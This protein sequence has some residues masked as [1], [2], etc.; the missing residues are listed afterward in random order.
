MGQQLHVHLHE[1]QR[2]GTNLESNTTRRF[3]DNKH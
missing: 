3:K 1:L 2:Y